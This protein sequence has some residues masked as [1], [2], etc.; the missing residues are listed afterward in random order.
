MPTTYKL[1]VSIENSFSSVIQTLNTIELNV[2]VYEGDTDW[3]SI[4]QEDA[5]DAHKKIGET[6]ETLQK[7]QSRIFDKWWTIEY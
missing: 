5:I 1:P 3:S 2:K 4:S 6:I 7:A